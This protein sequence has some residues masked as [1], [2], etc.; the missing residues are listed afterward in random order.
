MPPRTPIRSQ[1]L[2]A[3]RA[4]LDEASCGLWLTP[5]PVSFGGLARLE[6]VSGKIEAVNKEGACKA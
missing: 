3:S 1:L 5:D 2:V 4:Q 6:Q